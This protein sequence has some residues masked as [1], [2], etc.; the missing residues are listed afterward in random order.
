MTT[1]A[2]NVNHHEASSW[3]QELR[4]LP[5]VADNVNHH[6]ASSWHQ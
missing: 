6:E 3:H 4:S 2:D 1:V 5:V